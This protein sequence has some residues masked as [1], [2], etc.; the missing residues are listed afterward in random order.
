M[1]AVILTGVLAVIA[2]QVIESLFVAIV[3]TGAVLIAAGTGLFV[4]LVQRDRTSS[5]VRARAITGRVVQVTAPRTAQALPAPQLG[6]IAAPTRP[7]GQ[8][9]A[10]S[11]ASQ[12]RPRHPAQPLA[13]GRIIR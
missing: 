6:A 3:I 12:L 8:P 2:A 9:A 4:W 7:I 5:P 10:L 1:L 11:P 13:E